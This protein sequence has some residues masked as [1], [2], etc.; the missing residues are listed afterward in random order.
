MMSLF[1]FLY[2]LFDASVPFSIQIPSRGHD[3]TRHISID[4]QYDAAVYHQ[5]PEQQR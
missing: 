1:I 3:D 5:Q 4:H 2:T